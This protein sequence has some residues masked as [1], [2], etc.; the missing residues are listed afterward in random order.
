MAGLVIV[1]RCRLPA[2]AVV[3]GWQAGGVRTAGELRAHRQQRLLLEAQ[4]SS[5]LLSMLMHTVTIVYLSFIALLH[6]YYQSKLTQIK[7]NLQIHCSFNFLIKKKCAYIFETGKD[8][9]L[10]YLF[11]TTSTSHSVFV[12]LM[13]KVKD[14]ILHT[15]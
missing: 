9:T 3:R 8:I 15:L 14:G 7:L 10:G 11:L 13:G 5:G 6:V 2:L 4:A 1:L 12:C